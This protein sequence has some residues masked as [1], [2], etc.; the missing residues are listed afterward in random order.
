MVGVLR[1]LLRVCGRECRH[2]SQRSLCVQWL[3]AVVRS[4]VLQRSCAV[5]VLFNE[6]RF[7]KKRIGFFQSQRSH[8]FVYHTVGRFSELRFTSSESFGV[9]FAYFH[10]HFSV[11]SRCKVVCRSLNVKVTNFDIRRLSFKIKNY[12]DIQSHGIQFVHDSPVI[13]EQPP[14][15]YTITR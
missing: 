11:S 7:S 2:A 5:V 10:M 12:T 1:I 4:V 9:G 3:C 8:V 6:L 13:C 15:R 14:A